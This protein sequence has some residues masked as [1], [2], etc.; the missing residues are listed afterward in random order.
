M[1]S[2]LKLLKDITDAP[3]VPGF[4]HEVRKVIRSYMEGY[5]EISMDRIGSIICKKAGTSDRPRVMLAGH[6]DE[7]GFMV[8]KVTKEGFIKFQTLGGWWSQ[9]MLGQRVV[10][11]TNK[12][13]VVGVIGSKPPHILTPE[14]KNKVVEIQAMFIDVGASDETEATETFGIRLG[15]P[16]IPHAEFT[17]MRNEKYLMAKAWDDRL[18]CALFI[19]VVRALKD[20][21]HP[22]TVY[23]V[24]T[25]QEEVGLRGATTSS[26]VIDPD[27]GF[28]LEVGIAGDSP[29][30]DKMNEKLGKGPVVLLYDSSMI[31]HVKLRDFV[32]DVAKANGIPLQFDVLS[33]GGTDAGRIHINAGGVPSLCIAVPTRY[34]HSHYGIIHRDDYE[35]AVK[36]VL[37]LVKR[38]DASA[39]AQLNQD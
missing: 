35:N 6:M 17:V 24:G 23:G 26:H 30:A 21:E 22:N 33:A 15:D 9:V 14:E 8:S 4:E 5:A 37:E 25:V 3:G 13:D 1:D 38:L 12:G 20:I 7:I 29:G 27:I 16:I 18:G 10:I 11:K 2:T 19:E 28:A 39:V 34:I 31:P 36:L 32:I